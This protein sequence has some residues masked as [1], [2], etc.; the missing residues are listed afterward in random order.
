MINVYY[1]CGY[2]KNISTP[3]TSTPIFK[4]DSNTYSFVT[5]VDVASHLFFNVSSN[6]EPNPYILI[7]TLDSFDHYEMLRIIDIKDRITGTSQLNNLRLNEGGPYFMIG[8]RV[9]SN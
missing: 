2:L 8:E 9:K 5:S 3:M 4:L 1:I 7:G 6:Q